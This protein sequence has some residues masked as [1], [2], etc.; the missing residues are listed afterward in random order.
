MFVYF[1]INGLWI[2]NVITTTAQ[3]IKQEKKMDMVYS[4]MAQSS[5]TATIKR[6]T[7]TSRD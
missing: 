1:K 3:H 5:A 6:I 4:E 2:M 7:F